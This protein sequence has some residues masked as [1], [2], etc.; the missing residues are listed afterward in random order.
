MKIRF[1]SALLAVLML[2]G[3]F[4]TIILPVSAAKDEEGPDIEEVI[5]EHLTTV[6]TTPQQK[7]SVMTKKLDKNGYELWVL[8]ETGEIA[9]VDK[10][11]EQITFSNPWNVAVGT[12]SES[13]KKEV[14]SQVFINYNNNGKAATMNS[15]E[16]AAQ[17]GQIVVKNIK[18]G[19]RVEYTIGREETRLLV[20]RY[21]KKSRFETQIAKPIF[22][23]MLEDGIVDP[24]KL[25]EHLPSGDF[26]D[27]LYKRVKVPTS[28]I[29]YYNKFV[30]LYSFKDPTAADISPELQANIYKT[31]P[32]TKKIGAIFVLAPDAS[33]N[34]LRAHEQTI[35]TYCPNYN[36]EE[37]DKDHVE[38]EYEGTDKAPPLFKLALEY[39][40]DDWGLIVTLPASGLRFNESLYK[41]D[42][43]EILPYMG[44]GSNPNSGYTVFPDGSGTLFD[45]QE[46]DTKQ[47]VTISGKVYGPD[48]AYH[49]I[50]GTHQEII[51]YPVFGIVEN[52]KYLGSVIN[53]PIVPPTSGTDESGATTETTAP[54]TTAPETSA[55]E[56]SVGS[57]GTT[58]GTDSNVKYEPDEDGT[59]TISSGLL[60]IIEE[61]DALATITTHHGGA[62]SK[63]NT[64][65][66]SFTPRPKDTYDLSGSLAVGT[67]NTWE[68]VSKRKYVG[69]YK[70]RYIMMTDQK[71][72]QKNNIED[73]YEP[74][75]MG[76]AS[77]YS[78]YLVANGALKKLTANDIKEDIPLFVETFGTIETLEKILS[79]PVN[80]MTPLS[81]FDDIK[82]MYDELSEK[83]VGN[84]NFK[85][86]GYANGGV[87]SSI[88]AALKWEKAV[89]GN[90]GFKDLVSYA[91]EKDFGIFPDFDFVFVRASTDTLFDA[92]NLKKHAVKTID[93]RYTS[94]REYSAT[95]QS[96]VSYYDLAVSPEHFI[97][98]YNKLSA[99]YSKY[100]TNG[101]S[102]STLGQNINSNFDEDAPLNREDSKTYTVKLFEQLSNDYDKVMTDCGNYYSWSYVDYIVN[103]P[104]SSSRYI[105]SSK[106]VPFMGVVLH[107]FV[108]FA[109]TPTNMEGNIS[110]AFLKAIENGSGLYFKLVYRNAEKLKEDVKL[111]QNYSVRYDIWKDD[112]IIM[113]NQL[114]ELISD[115]QLSRIVAHQFL[116]GYRVPDQSE[117]DADNAAKE[118][119]EKLDK[120]QAELEAAAQEMK[121]IYTGRTQS[122]AEAQKYYISVSKISDYIIKESTG[123]YDKLVQ[124]LDHI[125]LVEKAIADATAIKENIAKVQAEYDA[126]V[127]A[128]DTAAAETKK[129]ELEALQAQYK[130]ICNI[131]GLKDEDG[132]AIYPDL[133][134]DGD[135]LEKLQKRHANLVIDVRSN[136][137]MMYNTYNGIF[138]QLVSIKNNVELA[139]KAAA[140][141]VA[142]KG[143]S[144]ELEK[145][146]AENEKLVKTEYENAKACVNSC[147]DKVKNALVIAEKYIYDETTTDEDRKVVITYEEYLESLAKEE[148]DKKDEVV[149]DEEPEEDA[150]D[151][152]YYDNS[153]NI[154]LVKFENGKTFILNYNYFDVTV[155]VD[156]VKYTVEKCGFDSE[157]RT[158]TG[159]LIINEGGAQ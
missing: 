132:D 104:L 65:K 42:D 82:S 124:K 89:G 48:Y 14:M 107:S 137:N 155:V 157:T 31:W 70:I 109:G 151:N 58:G 55:P 53:G 12:E 66:M 60:C 41:L 141:F 145:E 39:T 126:L 13:T 64:V 8:P 105:K 114:N 127:K 10:A 1:L 61:G 152:R 95:Y 154:V 86:T 138:T 32:A 23:G 2:V 56:T 29:F 4:A 35:K 40:I 123:Y 76:M 73:S 115:V 27:V 67:G 80:V 6:Y 75:W 112:M 158:Y 9:F 25:A 17:R 90:D 159:Y 16:E 20:P 68:V 121:D 72:A 57:D 130:D 131:E 63:Y 110:Y 88:P 94:R 33:T 18:N 74:T 148:E 129:A 78:D 125:T 5:A 50:S 24:E 3:T 59:V 47:K 103:V 101:I 146:V 71:I 147:Y 142:S 36:Y 113:Y 19:L 87:Y 156:G 46:L 140:Y 96:Y 26:R 143:F 116:E 43:I 69:N 139:G 153:G 28:I 51:R 49:T 22:E 111:S 54:E 118:E 21:I 99:N 144:T 117:I 79:V 81:S 120:I 102:V 11:S 133:M 149:E 37:L 52:Y 108:Q 30:T 83:G 45:F 91:E 97:Y 128:N 98:F 100:T 93:G 15:F 62:T 85:L 134:A 44:A 92:L 77:A 119:Q 38:C 84:I 136:V 106:S 122:L 34:E 150:L 135:S 7:L